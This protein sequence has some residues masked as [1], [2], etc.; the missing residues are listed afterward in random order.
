MGFA[1][2]MT[3]LC[4]SLIRTLLA[5]PPLPIGQHLAKR[6]VAMISAER[7]LLPR[8]SCPNGGW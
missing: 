4:V 3:V 2:D 1:D 7:L 5:T 8:W 6:C